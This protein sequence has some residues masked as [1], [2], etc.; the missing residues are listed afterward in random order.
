[1]F[2]PDGER[3]GVKGNSG[4]D[5]LDAAKQRRPRNARQFRRSRQGLAGRASALW[6]LDR[7]GLLVPGMIQ[8]KGEDKL[9]ARSIELRD[10]L[11]AAKVFIAGDVNGTLHGL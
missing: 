4:P 6:R 7:W 1:L 2:Y 5:C 10:D 9:V 11:Q 8:L 3:E